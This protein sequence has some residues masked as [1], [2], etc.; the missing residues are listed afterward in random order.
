MVRTRKMMKMG[1][2]LILKETTV[3]PANVPEMVRIGIFAS[4]NISTAFWL[5]D[6]FDAS[7][8]LLG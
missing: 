5:L 8:L 2:V 6:I 7:L 4:N 1:L 3:N